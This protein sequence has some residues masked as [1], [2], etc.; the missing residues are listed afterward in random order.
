MK[1]AIKKVIIL[2]AAL[3]MCGCSEG[4][5]P[6]DTAN[7][8]YTVSLPYEENFENGTINYVRDCN[9]GFKWQ[10]NSDNDNH[11]LEC[12]HYDE[13]DG[14]TGRTILHLLVG[15]TSWHDYSFSFDFRLNDDSYV[16]FAPY[17]D[18]NADNNTDYDFFDSRNPWSLRINSDGELSYNTVFEQ[19]SHYIV[20]K[21]N[22]IEGFKA[23]GWNHV[24]LI[25]DGLDLIMILNDNNIGK[26][27][28]L[29]EINS[30]RVSIGGG[31]GCMF[32]NLSIADIQRDT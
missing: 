21:P 32:D 28:E 4:Y 23:N 13:N 17:A 30:G 6:L 1:K 18:T 5:L 20:Q 27:A 8:N 15:D 19:G 24:E 12:V 7:N 16:T 22:V 3:L 11:Y 9:P 2:S 31:V 26:V 25:P 29:Q 10:I 14:I